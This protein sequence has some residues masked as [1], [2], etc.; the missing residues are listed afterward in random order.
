MNKHILNSI[1][2]VGRQIL[3]KDSHLWLYG[4]QARGDA[5]AKSDWDLLVL[6]DKDKI[7]GS[8]YDNYAFP[9]NMLGWQHNADISPVLYTMKEWNENAITLFH[10]NVERDKIEL[11]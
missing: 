2:N 10:F 3:P 11:I 1:K 8:D 4:S 9:L 5:H 6:L 7:E